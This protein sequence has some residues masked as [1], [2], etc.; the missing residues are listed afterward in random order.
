MTTYHAPSEPLV[1]TAEEAAQHAVRAWTATQLR[2]LRIEGCLGSGKTSTAGVVRTMTGAIVISTDDFLPG[3]RGVSYAA[4]LDI[5]AARKAARA[6]LAGG[7]KVVLEGVCLEEV[8]PSDEFGSGFRLYQKRVGVNPNGSR[9]IDEIDVL[10]PD[11]GRRDRY[12]ILA[13]HWKHEPHFKADLVLAVHASYL[14]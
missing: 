2:I 3:Q 14:A 6:A 9:W 12:G 11:P 5:E 1:C 10:Y 13:Y 8:L 7:G 4:S